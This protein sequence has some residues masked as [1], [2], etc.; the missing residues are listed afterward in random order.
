MVISNPDDTRKRKKKMRMKTLKTRPP[1]IPGVACH[2]IARRHQ[3]LPKAS[4]SMLPT[5]VIAQF[6]HHSRNPT[7]RD[8]RLAGANVARVLVSRELGPS[9]FEGA[10]SRRLLEGALEHSL[11]LPSM[12]EGAASRGGP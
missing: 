2:I 7:Q 4:Q 10:P 12:S 1:R 8:P 11:E 9:S 5:C 6:A 3:V